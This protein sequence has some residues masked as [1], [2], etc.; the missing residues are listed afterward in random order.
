MKTMN[1]ELLTHTPDPELVIA[2]AARTCYC[3][4]KKDLEASRK[5]IRAIVKSGHE[6]CVEHASATFRLSNV[7]RA[8]THEAVRHRLF[9]FS[10]KSQ[11]YVKEDKPSY[12]VPETIV[13]NPFLEG[14]FYRAMRAAWDSYAQL[15][16]DGVKPEDARFVLPNACTTEIVVSGNFREFRNFLK[17]RLSPRAQ[18]EIRKAANIILDKL[19]EI[20]PSCFED[21]KDGSSIQTT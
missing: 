21:L 5:M 17:L 15:L 8:L 11:R 18:W 14:E 3:S 19:Y 13:G 7:S 1:I 9:S 2:D 6:S 16:K 20:A 10:Q 4:P 12:V